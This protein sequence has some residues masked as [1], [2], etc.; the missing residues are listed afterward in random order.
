MAR[1]PESRAAWPGTAGEVTGGG[2]APTTREPRR[3]VLSVRGW[4]VRGKERAASEAADVAKASLKTD[5]G[6]AAGAKQV[7][8]AQCR[9]KAVRARHTHGVW[10]KS[11]NF[12]KESSLVSP[13]W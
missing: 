13:N 9:E 8:S 7:C 11:V 3:L 10:H 1:N 5:A 12:G 6:E 4:Q 2:P